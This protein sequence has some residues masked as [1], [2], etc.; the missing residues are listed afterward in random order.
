MASGPSQDT[1]NDDETLVLTATAFC[2]VEA[3][4]E[5]TPFYVPQITFKPFPGKVTYSG[6]TLDEPQCIFHQ[7][8]ESDVWLV[9]ALNS[10]VPALTAA[11]LGNPVPYSSF[12]T[13]NYYHIYTRIASNYLCLDTAPKLNGLI[14]VGNETNCTNVYYCNGPLTKTGP[15]RVKFVILNNNNTLVTS[16]RW[17]EVISLNTGLS[18]SNLNPWPERRSAGMIV[19]VVILSVLLAVLLACLIAA[20]AVGSKDICWCHIIDNEDFLAKDEDSESHVDVVN[21]LYVPHKIYQTHSKRLS[22]KATT[23]YTVFK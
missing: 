4:R 21:M 3:E 5:D 22:Q 23:V 7:Y 1:Y 16:T 2:N 8:N 12:Q 9:V 14:S 13:K 18:P 10:V 19:I 15:Y 17:S 20:L 6:F 11:N